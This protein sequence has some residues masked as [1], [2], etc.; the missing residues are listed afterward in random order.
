MC[1]QV[2]GPARVSRLA[3]E[4]RVFVPVQ[5]PLRRELCRLRFVLAHLYWFVLVR[6]VSLAQALL[7]VRAAQRVVPELLF[8]LV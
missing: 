5:V 1:C 3:V 7:Q 4:A 8:V 2:P 6:V